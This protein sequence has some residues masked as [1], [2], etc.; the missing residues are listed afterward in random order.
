VD[1]EICGA[2]GGVR[3]SGGGGRGGRYRVPGLRLD[4]LRTFHRGRSHARECWTFFG[5]YA[6][7]SFWTA[8]TRWSWRSVAEKSC[9][10]PRNRAS[11]A[12]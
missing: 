1:P 10:V 11:T 8:G 6:A 9:R 12:L 5:T 4:P 3:R 7:R 2:G